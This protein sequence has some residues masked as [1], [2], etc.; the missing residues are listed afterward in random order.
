[1]AFKFELG[2][3]VKETV[4]GF[5]GVIVGRADYLGG[6]IRYGVQNL[7]LDENND[8]TK[9]EWFDE[10]RLLKVSDNPSPESDITS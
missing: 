7:K 6:L 8:T 3:A 4:T 10:G 1:M 2:Q 5:Q 9:E